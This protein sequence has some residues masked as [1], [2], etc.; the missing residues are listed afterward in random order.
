VQDRALFAAS[1]W[2]SAVGGSFDLIVSN[3]PYIAS[4]VIPGLDPDVREHDPLLALDGGSDGL[5]AYRIILSEAPRLLASGGF[6]ILEIGYDQ[7]EALHALTAS[8]PLAIRQIAH[9]LA[10]NPRCVVL[11][12][13]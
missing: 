5:D 3:P 7:A 6:L 10:G 12:R 13:G 11:E 8:G 1:D 9:D 4:T 2:A